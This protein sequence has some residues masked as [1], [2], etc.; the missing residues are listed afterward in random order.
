MH[1]NVTTELE[2][3]EL[4]FKSKRIR[5]HSEPFYTGRTYLKQNKKN[6]KDTKF[7]FHVFKLFL[8]IY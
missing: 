3:M 5:N 1:S 7:C 6:K 8:C 4:S 2:L